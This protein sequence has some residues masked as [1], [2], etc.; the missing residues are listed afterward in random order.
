V[1]AISNKIPTTIAT[2]IASNLIMNWDL[3]SSIYF[4]QDILTPFRPECVPS[5][6]VSAEEFWDVVV[7]HCWKK[8]P[9][10]NDPDLI[11]GNSQ[12]V[13]SNNSRCL[14]PRA[15]IPLFSSAFLASIHHPL[16]MAHATI[17]V[18]NLGPEGLS[19]NRFLLAVSACF[20]RIYFLHSGRRAGCA[21]NF[22]WK[23]S[24]LTLCKDESYFTLFAR[25]SHVLQW[26]FCQCQCLLLWY[27]FLSQHFIYRHLSLISPKENTLIPG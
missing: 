14:V 1:T 10:T 26:S 18:L 16:H 9:R 25:Y 11:H 13:F 4:Q 23:E 21:I 19:W 15:C 3:L 12:G 24:L 22:P 2:A 17:A 7:F 6:F 27:N 20:S 5:S 8:K